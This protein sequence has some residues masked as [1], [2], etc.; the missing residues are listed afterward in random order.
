MLWPPWPWLAIVSLG[1]IGSAAATP[2]VKSQAQ[3]LGPVVL[4]QDGTASVTA[5]YICSE[6]FHLWVSAKQS[7]DGRPDSRLQEEGS[8]QHAAGWMQR[9]PEPSEFSCDGKWH[10]GTFT[11]VEDYWGTGQWDALKPGQAWVQFC[12]IGENEF[13]S[14]SRW[15]QVR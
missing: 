7:A 14:E 13:I 10:T 11:I 12:L 8:S 5:R 6:G 9:H 4:N 3:V 2:K 1:G 15:A